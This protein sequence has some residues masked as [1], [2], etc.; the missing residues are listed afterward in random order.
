MLSLVVVI[1]WGWV[2]YYLKEKHPE[3]YEDDKPAQTS[4]QTQ[5]AQPGTQ[6]ATQVAT[7]Q[8]A[9]V[10]A[11]GGEARP[12][13]IG[14]VKFDPQ[15]KISEY[16]IG[17]AIDPKGAAISSATLNRL[18]AVVGKEEP[19]VYQKP[20]Q[21]LDP[22]S[23]RSL[24]TQAITVDGKR[25]E[26]HNETWVLGESNDHS[27]TYYVDVVMA[28]GK[29]LRV[30]KTYTLR[31]DKDQSFGY[32]LAMVYRFE[33][34]TALPLVIRTFFNGPTVPAPENNRDVPEVVAG[35]NDQRQVTLKHH[36]AASLNPDKEPWDIMAQEKLPLLWTGWTSAYF[37]SIVRPAV[38]PAQPVISSAKAK[39]LAKRSD[40]GQDFTAISFETTDLTVAA[41]Q[42]VSLPF[43][44]Y[45]GPRQRAILNSDYYSQFPHGYNLT[46]V[47][48]GGMC[49]FCTFEPLIALMVKLLGFFHMLT[50][51]WGLAIMCLVIIVRLLLHPI[52]KRSQMSMSK[53]SKFG[54][55][56]ERLKQKYGDDKESLNREMMSFTKEH[57]V[58]TGLLGCLPMLLQM[59]IWIALWSS[60]QSTFELRHASFL[61][62]YTWI[63]DLAQPDRLIPFSGPVTL[64]WGYIHFDA[65]NILPI[66]MGIVFFVQQ[67]MT[68]KPPTMTKEQESQYKM[69]QWMSL[70]F[71]IFLYTGPSGL[72]LYIL[73]STS[74]GIIESKR[75]RDHIKQREEAEKSEKVIVDAKPTRNSKKLDRNEPEPKKRRGFAGWLADLQKKAEDLR[76]EADRQKRKS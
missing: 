44:V 18:R 33:N 63:K 13:Q 54:P 39:A 59:P 40:D 45:L 16:P 62:G 14:S 7:T 48:T 38:D 60:L 24:V 3:W 34:Q 61:W 68:P 41:G 46:L 25:I 50:R 21:D 43:D 9:G 28:D 37:D 73:T 47:L 17:L 31:P 74:I 29:K 75:I 76:R 22:A 15:G 72:N 32:E 36:S 11:V 69:M 4:G 55:E 2:N 6:P 27:A 5:S 70:L 19:Y 35:Y 53:L 56:I 12:K 66:L 52:T 1:G 8:P 49:G 26:L 10:H 64:F 57:G 65:I 30:S 42:A 67:K 23:S 20:Y 58:S 51:D 71:P